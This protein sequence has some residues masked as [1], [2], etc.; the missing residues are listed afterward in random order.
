VQAP[1]IAQ[2]WREP[3]SST[4]VKRG[5]LALVLVAFVAINIDN[6]P[7]EG[8]EFVESLKIKHMLAAH[9]PADESAALDAYD[10]DHTP[11]TFVIDPK[12]IVRLVE[13]GYDRGDERTL[14]RS[15]RRG[16]PSAAGHTRSRRARAGSRSRRAPSCQ[17]P[18]HH[19]CL[20]WRRLPGLGG[21]AGRRFA[22]PTASRTSCANGDHAARA[23]TG[24]ALRS[25]R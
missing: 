24:A 11:S 1:Y 9:L 18:K 7:A 17:L 23:G 13:Y 22:D 15:H 3:R 5:Q 20:H 4:S 16:R 2:N 6:H 12:G 8:K 14:A 21:A 25:A 19:G 10:P